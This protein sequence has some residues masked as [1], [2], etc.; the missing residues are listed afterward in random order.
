MLLLDPVALST[1]GGRAC[2]GGGSGGDETD[3]PQVRTMY[4]G[5]GGGPLEAEVTW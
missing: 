3:F 4:F 5:T 2:S 1:H